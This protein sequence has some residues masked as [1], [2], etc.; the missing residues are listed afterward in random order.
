L[1]ASQSG[2]AGFALPTAL[3]AFTP[4]ARYGRKTEL[5]IF[6]RRANLVA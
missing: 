2:V 1:V 6:S 3:H 5:D 4:P